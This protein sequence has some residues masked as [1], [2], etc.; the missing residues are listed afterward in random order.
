MPDLREVFEMTTKQMGEPDLDSWREQE[1][2]QRNA[3]RNKK[4]G[5]IAV[6][7]T[8]VVAAVGIVTSDG[9]VD[10]TSRD[11]QRPGASATVG[12]SVPPT[13]TN[14]PA[15]EPQPARRAWGSVTT[16]PWVGASATPQVDYVIDLNTGTMTPLPDAIIQSSLGTTVIEARSHYAVSPDGAQ[17]AYVGTGEEGTPQIFVAGIDGSGIRQATHDPVGADWPAWSPDGTMVAYQ[18]GAANGSLFV[19]D[20]ATGESTQVADG[21]ALGGYGLQFT[22]DGAS[23]VYTGGSF[24]ADP[25]AEMRTVPVAGGQ[26]TILFGGG[27]RGMGAAGS[28]SLSPDGS[29]VTMVGHE[30]SGPGAVRF[31]VNADGTDL[32]YIRGYGS[33]PAGVWS[34]DGTRIVA[35]GPD[36]RHGH[37]IIV[38]VV[39]GDAL[40]VAAEGSEAIWLDDH[41]L[42][43]ER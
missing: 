16:A 14:A 30:V 25:G 24:S 27:H 9:L 5:A 39:T 28:G 38:D 7:A 36:R 12:P 29:L 17:L 42:L 22:P 37:I 41:T 20:L 3:T 43:L 2:R 1:K 23:L 33:N 4:L 35:L 21:V 8:I 40:V 19:L 13:P 18:E 32:R 6:V 11:E 26:S 31:V 10:R 34:P 15:V